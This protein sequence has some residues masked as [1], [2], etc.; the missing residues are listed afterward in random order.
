MNRIDWLVTTF[1]AKIR[2]AALIR[3]ERVSFKS[4]EAAIKKLLTTDPTS[5]ARFG[6]WLAETYLKESQVRRPF[7][8]EDGIGSLREGAG[9]F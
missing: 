9:N 7:T 1:G 3:H 5:N 4:D 8:R 6:R 2:S